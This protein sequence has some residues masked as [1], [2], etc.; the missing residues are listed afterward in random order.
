MAPSR[1]SYLQNF[2]SLCGFK[3]VLTEKMRR[4]FHCGFLT[5]SVLFVVIEPITWLLCHLHGIPFDIKLYQIQCVYL[6]HLLY[7]GTHSHY[8][9]IDNLTDVEKYGQ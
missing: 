8:P 5:F 4:G 6:R 3:T 1:V 7:F 9:K 2:H